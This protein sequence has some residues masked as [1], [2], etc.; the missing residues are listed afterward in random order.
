MSGSD[1]RAE[2]G[3]RS[4]ERV[5]QRNG[6][7]SHPWDTRV[8]TMD[9]RIPKLREGSYPEPGWSHGVAASELL[10]AN[11]ILKQAYVDTV[12]QHEAGFDDLA[13]A[14]VVRVCS[15]SQADRASARSLDVVSGMAS[16]RGRHRL[17]GGPYPY[18]WLDALTLKVREAV[19]DRQRQA[20]W[21][22]RRSMARASGTSSGWTWVPAFQTAPVPAGQTTTLARS[23]HWAFQWGGAGGIGRSSNSAACHRRKSSVGAYCWQRCRTHFM[24]LNSARLGSGGVVCPA[25]GGHHVSETIYHATLPR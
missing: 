12:H 7:R 5:T 20:W 16:D 9:L 25:L 11:V 6:Y 24:T 3:E 8:G 18:L 4:P 21:W 1:R 13:K 17:D 2:Y 14:G 22:R 19:Q 10:P 15:K 23:S